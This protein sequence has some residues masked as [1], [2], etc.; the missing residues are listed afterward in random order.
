MK[1]SSHGVTA[2]WHLE[3]NWPRRTCGWQP[4]MWR[5][6]DWSKRSCSLSNQSPCGRTFWPGDLAKCFIRRNSART[7]NGVRPGAFA[8]DRST[9]R[10]SPHSAVL[11]AYSNPSLP[12][13]RRRSRGGTSSGLAVRNIA[14]LLFEQ[15][16]LDDATEKINQ[17]FE[18]ESQLLADNPG[19][20]DAAD[21][22]RPS[23]RPPRPNPAT[24]TGRARARQSN[25]SRK[26][27]SS[28]RKLPMTVLIWVSSHFNWRCRLVT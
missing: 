28:R 4:S 27:S 25:L 6:A 22:P 11:R 12:A 14:E 16:E 20:L 9:G 3:R 21:Y 5:P 8:A 17:V 19:D 26:Q 10:S 2:T 23:L 18:V 7:F 1:N 13:I 15:G 24:G